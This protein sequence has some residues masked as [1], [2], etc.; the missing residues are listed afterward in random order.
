MNPL[1]PLL[2]LVTQTTIDISQ[3]VLDV[4]HN[5]ALYKT[6]ELYLKGFS[7]IP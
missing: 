4:T 5:N 2:Q 1:C 7:V 3:Y 6:H